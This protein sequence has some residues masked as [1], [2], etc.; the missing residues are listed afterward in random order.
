MGGQ[1]ALLGRGGLYRNHPPPSISAAQNP[2]TGAACLCPSAISHDGRTLHSDNAA[3]S[4][5]TQPEY[6][7]RDVRLRCSAEF[8]K[9][10]W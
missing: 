3:P 6:R 1:A 10:L 5:D 4:H 7:F 2:P 8:A 9:K